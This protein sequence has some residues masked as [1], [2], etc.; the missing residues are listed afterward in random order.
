M[1]KK[2][3]SCRYCRT[4]VDAPGRHAGQCVPLL[5]T[6]VL[7]E[8]SRRDLDLRP[9][10][11]EAKPPTDA[12]TSSQSTNTQRQSQMGA[13]APGFILEGFWLLATRSNHCYANSLLQ[14]LHWAVNIDSLEALREP[15]RG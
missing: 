1:M 11:Y 8:A 6:H 13:P 15:L 3:D 2:G 10:S 9:R 5:Q 12:A 14:T 4:K 7:Q